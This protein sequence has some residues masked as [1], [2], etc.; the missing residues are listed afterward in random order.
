MPPLPGRREAGR[1]LRPGIHLHLPDMTLLMML[2]VM[3]EVFRGPGIH[4]P[5]LLAAV[6]A[7]RPVEEMIPE[8]LTHRLV[9]PG[10]RVGQAGVQVA[11]A[12]VWRNPEDSRL[13]RL[14]E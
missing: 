6:L 7:V 13:A 1:H 2:H 10:R 11:E 3:H 9:H 8:G 14:R 4:D 5:L 12:E